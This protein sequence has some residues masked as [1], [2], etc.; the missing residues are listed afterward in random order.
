MK[1]R[2]ADKASSRKRT[3]APVGWAAVAV[4]VPLHTPLTWAIPADLSPHVQ[5]GV[6]VVVPFRSRATTGLVLSV[7]PS[8]PEGIATSRI[9]SIAD[10][11]D[12]R[13]LLPEQLLALLE[14]M[15]RYYHAPIGEVVRLAL[16]SGADVR[17]ERWVQA[18]EHTSDASDAAESALPEASGALLATLQRAG[19]EV[20]ADRLL[21]DCPGARFVDLEILEQQGR[22]ESTYR[23]GD[24]R[25]RTRT[26]LRV[27]PGTAAP[28][29][30][31]GDRQLQVTRFLAEHGETTHD[32]LRELYGTP[33]AVLQS[34]ARR[35]LVE[36]EEIEVLRD[37]FAGASIAPRGPD[38]VLTSGQ[39]EALATIRTAGAEAPPRP[40]LLHGV[41]GSGKT[42]VYL[43]AIRDTLAVG[44]RAVVLLPEIALTPQFVGVFRSVF[45]DTIAVLHSGLTPG[46]KWD[47]WRRIRDGDAR[48]VIGARSALFAP[49]HDLGLI[50]VDEEHDSSFKQDD[51]LRYNA[52]DCALVLARQ[53]GAHAVLGSA[54][55]SLESLG[56][57][58]R[59]RYALA[60]MPERANRRP[61]PHLELVD[62]RDFPPDAEDPLSGI[63]SPPLQR[64]IRETLEAGDQVILFL[65]RRGYAPM[66]TCHDCGET[67]QCPSCDVSLTWHRRGSV[68][69][70]HYCGF[71]TARPPDCP[72]C[73]SDN[74]QV[75]GTG[76]E[77]VEDRIDAAF[78]KARVGRLD[79]D[80]SRG[81]GLLTI[82]DRFR[83][84]EI[85]VLIGT[86]MV[87]KGHDFPGVTL[88]GV[89]NADQSLR[90][91]D[92]RSG[93]RTYQ[94]LTQVAGR[95]GR[96]QRPGRVLVQTR[97]PGHFALQ[98]AV[99]G[100]YQGFSEIEMQY[101]E[102]MV[103][104]PFGHLLA[105]RFDGP[106]QAAVFRAAETVEDALT[107]ASQGAL[108]IQGPVEAP[109][110]RLRNRYRVHILVR[111]RSRA[112][113]HRAAEIVLSVR[114][115]LSASWQKADVRLGLDLDPSSL[116]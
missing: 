69:R 94:L 24:Q 55:P 19:R 65:N 99:R 61:L 36:L 113:I 34:L 82:L 92:F 110:A 74:L 108:R 115:D 101:R 77:Q 1:K 30:R 50:L 44:R 31:L 33:R 25:Q 64:A 60:C 48:I 32:E 58:Q 21:R 84:R 107:R 105:L 90:F 3:S 78:P 57:C 37:P 91:P 20:Q 8:P 4:D 95:A 112:P 10:V 5:R 97:N 104:P 52:R 87:T 2:G 45:D 6:R 80:T 47:Q 15:A 93:E 29:D 79:R 9:R 102:R 81:R 72:T 86:Q 116:L 28:P 59:G 70:C 14:W 109:I 41:T 43:R 39:Q 46:E 18:V 62:L 111:C 7:S 68:L 27:R 63:L 38:P 26:T 49:V 17:T 71:S 11:L 13:P 88:V 23:A 54:T 53:H 103:W 114:A 96:A 12:V 56:N 16:P 83:R 40:V 100:D 85:D 51:G 75:D 98:A 106:E 22:A 76:T 89:L 66:M 67:L 42:E 73:R 35:S